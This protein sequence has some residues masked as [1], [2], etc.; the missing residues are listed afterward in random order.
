M[1]NYPTTETGGGTIGVEIHG[2]AYAFKHPENPSLNNTTFLSYKIFNRSQHTITDAYAG[3]L[4]DIDLGKH[5]D[6]YVGCDVSRGA[7][8][9]YNGTEIDG[10][11][12][13]GSL[14]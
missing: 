13:S 5:G 7:Y 9:G 8:Y 4:T 12:G 2:F 11:G 1:I 14:W 6:D 3:V 10:D